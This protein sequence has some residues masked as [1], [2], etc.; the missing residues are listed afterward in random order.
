MDEV[1]ADLIRYEVELEEKNAAL[2]DAQRLIASVL[3]SM[4]D[5]LIVCDL[6]GRI[7]RVNRALEDLTGI[8]ETEL[9]GRPFQDLVADDCRG[10]VD[11]LERRSRDDALICTARSV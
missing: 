3:A 4:S 1:Y 8:P 7:Q 10:L 11:A 9:V 5:V 2:E 6:H